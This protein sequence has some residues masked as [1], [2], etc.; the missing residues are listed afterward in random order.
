MNRKRVGQRNEI[1]PQTDTRGWQRIGIEMGTGWGSPTGQGPKEH[2]TLLGQGISW[3]RSL[4]GC[5]GCL[6]HF[7]GITFFFPSLGVN[8][9]AVHIS[10]SLV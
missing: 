6:S 8:K 9:C 10:S 5:R 3:P 2:V 4:A 7:V 1:R